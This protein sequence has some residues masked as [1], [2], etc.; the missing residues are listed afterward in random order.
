MDGM[1]SLREAWVQVAL[2]RG[3]AAVARELLAFLASAP[4]AA[5]KQKHGMAPA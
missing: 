5:A 3:A 2:D 4:L 1:R